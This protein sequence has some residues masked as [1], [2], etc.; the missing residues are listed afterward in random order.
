L[1]IVKP[2]PDAVHGAITQLQRLAELFRRRRVQLAQAAGLTEEQWR[3]LEQ[4]AT[5]HFMPSLFARSRETSAA[6]VSRTIR[7]LLDKKLVSVTVARDDG[8]QRRYVLTAKGTRALDALRERRRAAID[9]IWMDL[10]PVQLD[11]FTR[12]SGELAQRLETYA[13][14]DK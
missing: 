5:E 14:Q 6:A 9:A 4:I 8:R 3:V 2:A 1:L 11:A 10:D 7:Q 12:F 13:A